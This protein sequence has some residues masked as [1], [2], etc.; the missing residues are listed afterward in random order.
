MHGSQSPSKNAKK[1][2][3]KG[4]YGVIERVFEV[5]PELIEKLEQELHSFKTTLRYETARTQCPSCLKALVNVPGEY[6]RECPE[7]HSVF[8]YDDIQLSP[9]RPPGESRASATHVYL[10]HVLWKCGVYDMFAFND[11]T[12]LGNVIAQFKMYTGKSVN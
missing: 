3:I 5:S 9:V 6:I 11:I 10:K 4:P 1:I 8:E 7:C 12:F 2:I